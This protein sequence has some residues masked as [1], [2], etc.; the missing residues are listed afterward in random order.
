MVCLC[1]CH[2][3]FVSS[4]DL[5]SDY[6]CSICIQE[7]GKQNQWQLDLEEQVVQ[8]TFVG[9]SHTDTRQDPYSS[10]CIFATLVLY[11]S[12]WFGYKV[13]PLAKGMICASIYIS[14]V[15]ACICHISI[16][17]ISWSSALVLFDW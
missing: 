8:P 1:H 17:Y 4:S 14:V 3:S 9:S 6:P 5:A 10:L 12:S 13:E 15:S 2:V 16:V 11:L 7:E